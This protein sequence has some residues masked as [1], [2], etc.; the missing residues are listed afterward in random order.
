MHLSPENLNS[1]MERRFYR[2]KTSRM[3]ARH[4]IISMFK[5]YDPFCKSKMAELEI[6]SGK[7]LTKV[8]NNNYNYSKY[9]LI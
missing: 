8:I 6:T 1:S 4:H 5:E 3:G 9:F 7:M 2:V